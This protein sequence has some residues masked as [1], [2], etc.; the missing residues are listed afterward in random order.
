MKINSSEELYKYLDNTDWDSKRDT[1]ISSVYFLVTFDGHTEPI[2][3]TSYEDVY[4]ES[5]CELHRFPMKEDE[6]EEYVKEMYDKQYLKVSLEYEKT[7]QRGDWH[8]DIDVPQCTP[9]LPEQLDDIKMISES[10][11]LDW[12]LDHCKW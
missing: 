10:E 12:I 8:Y 2:Y 1:K 7:M 5:P 6:I 4:F 3:F 11:C 9:F